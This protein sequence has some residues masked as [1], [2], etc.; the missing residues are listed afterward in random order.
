[1]KE[2]LLI[3]GLTHIKAGPDFSRLKKAVLRE[4]ETGRVPFLEL[5]A[6]A[7]IKNA[8]LGEPVRN[9]EQE[10]EFWL[11]LGYDRVPAPIGVRFQF[12]KE[13]APDTA[14]ELARSER[15]WVNERTAIIKNW[16]D[17]ER[18]P[19]PEFDEGAIE[20]VE[21][22]RKILPDG[23]GILVQSSG[24][25]ENVMWLMGYEGLS[26]A[27][28]DTPGLVQEMFDRVGK[29]V[30]TCY[31]AAMDIEEVGGAFFGED[32]GFKTATM[33]SPD[34]MRKY[35]FP[36][37]KRIVDVC[38]EHGKFF[39]LHSCGRLDEIMNDLIDYVGIDAKHSFEDAIEPVAGFKKRYGDRIGIVGG[40]DV[41]ALTRRTVDEVRRYVRKILEDC[42]PGGG[43]ALGSGNSIAN[44][45]R[46]ENY[47]AMLEE[48]W[49]YSH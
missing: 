32:M 41:D 36:W 2:T 39:I 13:T 3:P 17:F 25:L 40:V 21:Q 30:L 20:Y 12:N 35:H 29:L 38:H 8:I 37:L 47:L 11:R 4:G 22:T 49:N 42:A 10:A 6:D 15:G 14:G 46:V 33:I 26:M 19:W 9:M 45:I 31:E 48:G 5:F 18:Y 34:A 28:Y 43:Y 24:V 1:M 27:L 16:D 23:M 44:Y 7:E